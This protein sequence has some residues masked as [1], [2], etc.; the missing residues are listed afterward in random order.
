V[1]RWLIFTVAVAL[2]LPTVTFNFVQDDRVIV[3]GNPAVHSFSLAVRGFARPYWPPPN[4]GGL[5]RPLT[6][7]SYAADWRLAGGRP[8]LFHLMNALWHGLAAVLVVLVVVRWLP[9][10]AAFAAGLVFALHPV[11]VEAIAGVVGRAEL[12]AAVGLLGA[13]V[14]ARRGWWPAAVACAAMAMFSKEHG[15]VAGVVVFIDDWLRPP[16]ARR[17]PVGFYVALGAVTVGFLAIWVKIGGAAAADVAPPFFGAGTGERLALALPAIARAGQLL[18]WP[19]GL[20]ADYGPQ[21]IPV[22]PGVSLAAVGGAVVVVGVVALGLRCRRRWP[23]LSFAALATVACFLP[24]SNLL[25]AS[26]IVLAERSLYVAVLLVAVGAGYAVAYGA[27]HWGSRRTSVAVA[28]LAVALAAGSFARLPVWRDNRAFLLT[29]LVDHP[30][31]Y[32]AH[33]SAAAVLAG[34]RDTAGARREYARAESLFG[35]DPHLNAD[36]ALYLAGLRDTAPA[37]ALAARARALLPREHVALRA[38]FLLAWERGD[39]ARARALADTARNWF[40]WDEPWYEQYFH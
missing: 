19:T 3:V 37:G 36:Y 9:E 7:L 32:H 20:S 35:G 25:F 10:P 15:V 27:V 30:E 28:V 14:S 24:A 34:L 5:Y 22:R 8:W 23:A 6:I 18:V 39:S 12:L 16:G 21:V 17:Y 26:G 13:V 40:L 11:H 4:A 31:S 38:Q 2:Y 33:A 29:L 1:K